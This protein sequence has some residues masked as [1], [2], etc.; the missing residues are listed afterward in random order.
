MLLFGYSQSASLK[1]A[2]SDI[3]LVLMFMQYGFNN[4]SGSM[5][6]PG[7]HGVYPFFVGE[8]GGIQEDR[9]NIFLLDF[10]IILQ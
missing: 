1:Y 4:F 7:V 10:R 8:F 9:L 3:E 6:L 2:K 5:A